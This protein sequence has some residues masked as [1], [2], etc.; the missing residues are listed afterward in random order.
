MHSPLLPRSTLP[1]LIKPCSNQY[2]K[3]P[4]SHS[5]Q[6]EPRIKNSLPQNTSASFKRYNALPPLIGAKRTGVVDIFI[7]ANA[8]VGARNQFGFFEGTFKE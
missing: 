8:T 4:K 7:K 3:A 5:L 1:L 2:R 6:E